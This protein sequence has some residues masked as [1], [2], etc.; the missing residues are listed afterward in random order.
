[1]KCSVFG[2]FAVVFF[3]E[4][5]V[6]YRCVNTVFLVL[7]EHQRFQAEAAV[8]IAQ[9]EDLTVIVLTNKTFH[10][11]LQRAFKDYLTAAIEGKHQRTIED[12]ENVLVIGHRFHIESVIEFNLHSVALRPFALNRDV[13]CLFHCRFTL[14]D[15]AVYADSSTL[16]P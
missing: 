9:V 1:M 8:C 3:S 13:A 2:G 12:G 10:H 14:N 16:R 11:I 5:V 4:V 6:I 15:L 7:N